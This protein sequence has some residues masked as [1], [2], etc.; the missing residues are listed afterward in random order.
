MRRLWSASI[1]KRWQ[2]ARLGP[3]VHLQQKEHT[4]PAVRTWAYHPFRWCTELVHYALDCLLH[5]QKL[6]WRAW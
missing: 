1:G 3:G 2:P 6:Q 4:T 5:E